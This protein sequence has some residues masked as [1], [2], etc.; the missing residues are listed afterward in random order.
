[1]GTGTHSRDPEEVKCGVCRQAY[2]PEC[3]YKQGRCPHHEPAIKTFPKW[4]LLLAAC[5][6]IPVWTVTHPRQVWQ[7]AKKDWKL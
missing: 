4:F 1:M 6:I 5:V 7:Q 2:T 3:N